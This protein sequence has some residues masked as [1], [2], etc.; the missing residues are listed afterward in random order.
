MAY[1]GKVQSLITSHID[2]RAD[3]HDHHNK[4]GAWIWLR[5]EHDIWVPGQISHVD[6]DA[7]YIYTP[8]NGQV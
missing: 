1:L 8:H 5:D 3:L 6:A 4:Q 7:I 2:Q